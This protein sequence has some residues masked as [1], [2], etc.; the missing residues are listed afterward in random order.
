[1]HRNDS[2][3]LTL[4]DNWILE[5]SL[6]INWIVS[7]DKIFAWILPNRKSCP[8]MHESK[9]ESSR[10]SY[11]NNLATK[12]ILR[13][14]NTPNDLLCGMKTVH[15]VQANKKHINVY[16]DR[17]Y[18]RLS[19]IFYAGMKWNSFEHSS[20][21]SLEAI[22]HNTNST[23][24]SILRTLND[25]GSAL[26][27]QSQSVDEFYNLIQSSIYSHSYNKDWIRS[28]TWKWLDSTTKIVE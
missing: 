4:D 16:S 28:T 22:S 19:M 27:T 9:N 24:F 12:V 7:R 8:C 11:T 25:Y 26:H 1:M 5:Q 20:A 6:K 17:A 14:R 15:N 21:V 10:L 3:K 18:I 13:C 2:F 23:I